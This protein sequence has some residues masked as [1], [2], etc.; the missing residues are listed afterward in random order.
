MDS[1]G[2]GSG[3]RRL[4]PLLSVIV[5]AAS[6]PIGTELATRREPRVVVNLEHSPSDS[7]VLP[8]AGVVDFLLSEEVELDSSRVEWREVSDCPATSP[9]LSCADRILS[10]DRR[11]RPKG[12]SFQTP[13]PALVGGRDYLIDIRTWGS[14]GR[15]EGVVTISARRR[16]R[17]LR[18][19]TPN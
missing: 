15:G 5:I 18:D 14:R 13:I 6:V 8:G 7:V 10:V 1:T 2:S 9:G 17:A 4:L 11:G 19:I 12:R 3:R 16:L